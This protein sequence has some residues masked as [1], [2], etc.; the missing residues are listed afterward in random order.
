M[1]VGAALAERLDGLTTLANVASPT[2][3]PEE[4]VDNGGRNSAV[5]KGGEGY[6]LLSQSDFLLSRYSVRILS[7]F[8]TYSVVLT[9]YGILPP[10]PPPQKICKIGAL[11]LLR[12]EYT[13]NRKNTYENT[14]QNTAFIEYRLVVQNTTKNTSEN[15]AQNTTFI[16]Y[17]LVVQNTTKNTSENTTQNT[18]RIEYC[19][20]Y[21]RIRD[22]IQQNTRDKLVFYVWKAGRT[23][24]F[25][26]QMR[27]TSE[28][29]GILHVGYRIIGRILNT[30][31]NTVFFCVFCAVFLSGIL[32]SWRIPTRRG[33]L[34]VFCGI[35]ALSQNMALTLFHML[36]F[37]C[38]LVRS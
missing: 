9:E 28:Y 10:P 4:D 11:F 32:N 30:M 34:S 37:L 29:S 36:V 19:P 17:R 22:R 12:Q 31:K 2:R 18:S 20:E 14:A 38:I 15:T 6:Y 25:C 13:K 7:V 3:P 1:L 8:C 24:L 16:E 27:L 23:F 5:A 33:I 26:P 21:N 35:L